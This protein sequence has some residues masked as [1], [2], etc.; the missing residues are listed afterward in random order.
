[1]PA[2]SFLASGRVDAL[3]LAAR[4]PVLK[5][6]D[7]ARSGRNERIVSRHDQGQAHL[8]LKGRQKVQQSGCRLVVEIAGRLVCEQELRSP[9]Q[10][11]RDADPLSLSPRQASWRK[12]KPMIQ[13]NLCQQISRAFFEVGGKTPAA[14]VAANT[15][16]APP[17]AAPISSRMTGCSSCGT[18]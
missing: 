7:A 11:P 1:M 13:A 16:V 4:P 2:G 5:V 3:H 12:V 14:P 15:A 10:R 9:E 8:T 18:A 6:Q 17:A